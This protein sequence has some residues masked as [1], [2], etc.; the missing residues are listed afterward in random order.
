[1]V[2]EQVERECFTRPDFATGGV[3]RVPAFFYVLSLHHRTLL[4]TVLVQHP[5]Q[6]PLPFRY[7]IAVVSG[8]AD[9][10]EA[11]ADVGVVHLDMKEDNVMVD[12]PEAMDFEAEQIA[13]D[14]TA[15]DYRQCHRRFEEPPEA[16]VVD[17]GTAMQF[18]DEWVV[19]VPAVSGSLT[20]P[21]GAQPWG[22][23]HHASPEL[24]MEWKRASEELER[25]N[26]AV[27]QAFRAKTTA[28]RGA[29]SVF[30][31]LCETCV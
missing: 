14:A 15:V 25:A 4:D 23:Q 27:A 17:W 10:L 11:A 13:A 29:S 24:C 18:V 2:A 3:R 12:D 9:A 8:I 5:L 7:V 20:L 31:C 22:N 30:R 16:V 19:V 1:M 26:V 6:R 28:E 21:E